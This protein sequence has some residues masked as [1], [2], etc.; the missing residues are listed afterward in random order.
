[1][2]EHTLDIAPIVGMGFVCK[3]LCSLE[4]GGMLGNK[5]SWFQH[6]SVV[7]LRQD[8]CRICSCNCFATM[9]SPSNAPLE[10]TALSIRFLN[11]LRKRLSW[12]W[13]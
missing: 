4:K 10:E 2:V 7:G 8:T 5:Y 12:T 9:L 11:D 13:G 3:R 6:V 1:M